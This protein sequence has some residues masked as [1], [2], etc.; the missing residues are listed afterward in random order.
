MKKLEQ[1]IRCVVFLGNLLGMVSGWMVAV[2]MALVGYEVFMRYIF[3]R[4]PI[5]ADEL[6]AYLLVG[7]SYVGLAY[8]YKTGGHVRITFLVSKLKPQLATWLRLCTMLIAE[9]FIVGMC[10]A[11]YQYLSF[12]IM[13]NEKSASWLNF[14][15]KYPQ[16]TLLIGFV[17][18]G[19]VVLSE[20]LKACLSL[21]RSEYVIT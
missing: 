2:M 16:A 18:Y 9:I 10:V 14:P 17:A 4:P 12:S 5:L 11:C 20:I 1:G 15:L 7:I 6:G 3:N 19:L 13:I 21:K 8:T